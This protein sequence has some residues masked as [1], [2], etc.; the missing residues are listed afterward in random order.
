MGWG[1]PW[2]ARGWGGGR[3]RPLVVKRCMRQRRILVWDRRAK[4]WRRRKEWGCASCWE[5]LPLAP[6]RGPPWDELCIAHPPARDRDPPPSPFRAPEP[7]AMSFEG[8]AAGSVWGCERCLCRGWRRNRCRRSRFQGGWAAGGGGGGGSA[9]TWT[10]PLVLGSHRHSGASPPRP[11]PRPRSS[12]SA[13]PLCVWG[14]GADGRVRPRRVK[15]I[16]RT[17]DPG[18]QHQG[19]GI[20][21]VPSAGLC[22]SRDGLGR[23]G[24]GVPASAMGRE[25]GETTTCGGGP[26]L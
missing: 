25:G 11:P 1:V 22:L 16:G 2:V 26:R 24:G 20:R 8:A 12:V 7:E 19:C 17:A 14:G 5:L 21:A 9:G 13:E 18:S 15:P 10:Q 3:L 4:G 23:G 6:G